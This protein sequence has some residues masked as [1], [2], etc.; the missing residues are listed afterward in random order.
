MNLKCNKDGD[1][2]GD[3]MYKEYPEERN[4]AILSL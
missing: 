4:L 2:G 1:G 3:D